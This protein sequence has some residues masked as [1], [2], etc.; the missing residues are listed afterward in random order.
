MSDFKWK[1]NEYGKQSKFFRENEQC[2]TCDQ[3]VEE[4][5]RKEKI[6][7]AE[8]K[9]A[10]VQEALDSCK[11]DIKKQEDILEGIHEQLQICE[12]WQRELSGQTA[13]INTI[14]Q[15]IRT[16]QSEISEL[17][18]GTGDLSSANKE[19]ETLRGDKESLQDD[20][21]KLGE[22][23]SYQQ[24]MGELLRDQGIKSKIIKQ[25]LPVINQLTN[26]YL[27]TLDFFVHF[28]LDEAFQ[29]TIRSRHRDSFS[30][31]SFS[32][33]EKQRIDLSLLFTW[34]QIAKMKNSVATNLLILDETF[35]SSLDAEGVDNL[36]KIL[37]TLGEDTNV[38]VISHKGELEDAQFQRKIEFVKDRNFSKIS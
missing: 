16:L 31:D 33:G 35:D 2:P 20:K 15:N 21:Y 18:E 8:S 1:L 32:E 25:Y 28:D 22:E 10:T 23:H 30:Y 9:A 38:F 11:K 17:S 34:R 5:H 36:M 29:E 24:V 37:Y 27:Q 26:Q 14:N 4:N 13:Q 7:T 6:A 19:L 3:A 12:V